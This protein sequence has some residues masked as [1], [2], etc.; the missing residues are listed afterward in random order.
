MK[1]LTLYLPNDKFL[2][3]F[4][5]KTFADHKLNLAEKLNFVLGKVE[6]VVG[7]KRRKCWLP[8][9]SPFSHNVS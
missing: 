2:D 4:K 1:E 9:F 6:N 5:L 3:W 8:I 7:G